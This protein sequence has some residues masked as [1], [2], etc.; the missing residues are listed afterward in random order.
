MHL[1]FVHLHSVPLN[2][3]FISLSFVSFSYVFNILIGM[4]NPDPGRWRTN[5]GPEPFCPFCPFLFGWNL[6]SGGGVGGNAMSWI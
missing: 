1:H 2:I 5:S 6:T 3:F 4:R